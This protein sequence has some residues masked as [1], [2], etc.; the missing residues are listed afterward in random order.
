[1]PRVTVV[2]PTFERTKYLAEA[3]P[4]ALDQTL[5]AI[6]GKIDDDAGPAGS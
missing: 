3:L 2:M 1:M 5:A 6:A 4:S